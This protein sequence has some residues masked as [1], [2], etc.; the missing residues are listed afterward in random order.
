MKKEI[1][2]K[3]LVVI[4]MTCLTF[5]FATLSVHYD[6]FTVGFRDTP[7]EWFDFAVAICA[8]LMVGIT[9]LGIAGAFIP[10]VVEIIFLPFD[11]WDY[12]SEKYGKRQHLINVLIFVLCLAFV[13][14]AVNLV[15]ILESLSGEHYRQ[16]PTF[17][18]FLA[19]LYAWVIAIGTMIV[20]GWLSGLDEAT[21]ASLKKISERQKQYAEWK[22][23]EAKMQNKRRQPQCKKKVRNTKLT[24]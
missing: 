15:A 21:V 8:I 6:V 2:G 10:E 20:F 1:I 24:K 16:M 4:A 19:V 5:I 17:G 9:G 14:Y 3:V 13:A 18:G 22:R 23:K 7:V 11:M 12:I